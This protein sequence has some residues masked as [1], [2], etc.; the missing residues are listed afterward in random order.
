MASLKEIKARINSV[1][2]T[3]KITQAMKMV[4]SAKLRRVQKLYNSL[5]AYRAAL[6][7]IASA[8][9]VSCGP[10]AGVAAGSDSVAGAA[11]GAAAVAGAGA[12]AGAGAGAVGAGAAAGAGAAGAGA[13]AA[14][15]VGAAASAGAGSASDSVAGATSG[16]ASGSASV[17]TGGRFGP[18]GASA[19]VSPAAGG[20]V[21]VV[22]FSSDT[23]LCGSYNANIFRAL[24]GRVEQ[25][26]ASGA[27]AE[28]IP[29]GEKVAKMA[30]KAYGNLRTDFVAAADAQSYDGIAPLLEFLIEGY[31]AGRYS[32]VELL[33]MH[34]Y[35][36]SRQKIECRTYLGGPLGNSPSGAPAPEAAVASDVAA[37]G[38]AS[39]AAGSG[40]AASGT[41][42]SGT[43]TS[44]VSASG[45]AATGTAAACAADEM[46][47]ILEPSAAEI[48]AGI[49]D[50]YL[51][52]DL[53]ATLL[54]AKLSEH[55]CRMVAMQTASDNAEDL[56]GELRLTFNK[57]RQSDI[58]EELSDISNSKMS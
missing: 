53:Y 44:G 27:C 11:S 3:L 43:A 30:A 13:A 49:S 50:L 4:S 19:G 33:Y 47:V 45:A 42:G 18:E 2:S 35:S 20:K 10:G 57:Q 6:G 37:R 16:S 34:F 41:A 32:R 40:A 9:G 54:S 48:A 25:I 23:S 24:Q 1:S 8:A 55:A 39:G 29:V 31:A 46:L 28:I 7:E 58:T 56:L 36:V 14:A 17:A 21:A 26:A 15:V 51:R 22:V 5:E 38:V 52:A 12:S